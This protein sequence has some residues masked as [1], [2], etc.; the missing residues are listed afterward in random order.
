L[1]NV[2][3][4]PCLSNE[5]ALST[6]LLCVPSGFTEESLP[7]ISGVR[8]PDVRDALKRKAAEMAVEKTGY[9]RIGIT[10]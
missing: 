10:T 3:Y 1:W 5:K 8:N 2:P 6:V 4:I 9:S 7:R